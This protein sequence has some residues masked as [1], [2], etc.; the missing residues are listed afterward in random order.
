M[1]KLSIA[2]RKEHKCKC[3]PST[4]ARSTSAQI[5]RG[6]KEAYLQIIRSK[7]QETCVQVVRSKKHA[8]RSGN[9]WM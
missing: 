1:S 3:K 2:S 8:F 9:Q 7:L 4:S 6:K 5:V